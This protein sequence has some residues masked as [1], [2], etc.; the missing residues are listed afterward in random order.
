MGFPGP[1][2]RLALLFT[3]SK[4][5]TRIIHNTH[6]M[7]TITV[8]GNQALEKTRFA[9]FQD[10]YHYLLDNQL[11]V[12]MG[13]MDISELS[14]ESRKRYDEILTTPVGQLHNL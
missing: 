6:V 12:E 5:N 3:S 1:L 2:S 4:Y 8:D 11:I 9:D 14:P 13:E 7:T 10:L